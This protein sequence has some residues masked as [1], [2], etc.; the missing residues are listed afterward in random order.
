MFLKIR[1][2]YSL[3]QLKLTQTQL[4]SF[5]AQSWLIYNLIY[6][7]KKTQK[8]FFL[9]LSIEPRFYNC[10]HFGGVLMY[11]FCQIFF[12]NKLLAC[13]FHFSYALL[14]KSCN[15][16]QAGM[17]LITD[18]ITQKFMCTK[19]AHQWLLVELTQLQS[20]KF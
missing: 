12:A 7:I 13:R 4:N 1:V 19:Q 2:R 5:K 20:N 11:V 15:F 8:T 9:F 6:I 3:R 10:N 18:L 17:C 14:L 16:P